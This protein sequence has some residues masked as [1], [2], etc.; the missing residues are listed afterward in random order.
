MGDAVYGTPTRQTSSISGQKMRPGMNN[1]TVYL[2]LISL[3]FRSKQATIKLAQKP[4]GPISQSENSPAKLT[5]RLEKTATGRWKFVI[6]NTSEA[7]AQNLKLKL[8]GIGEKR[9]P[10]ISRKFRKTIRLEKLSRNSSVTFVPL[11]KGKIPLA[12]KAFLTWENNDG[13]KDSLEASTRTRQLYLELGHIGKFVPRMIN[14]AQMPGR[15]QL[16]NQSAQSATGLSANPPKPRRALRPARD[17]PVGIMSP[18]RLTR[19]KRK[20]PRRPIQP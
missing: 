12:Y 5:L 6:T 11:C 20:Y 13:S 14:T 3:A 16:R 7:D 17:Y 19:G 10:F 1:L 8:L 4:L 2:S 9:S 15:S 18:K